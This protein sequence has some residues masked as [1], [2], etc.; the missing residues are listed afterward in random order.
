ML[1]RSALFAL[2]VVL[3]VASMALAACG[4]SDEEIIREGL[5][6]EFN[7]LKDTSSEEFSKISSQ[8]QRTLDQQGIKIEG[9]METWLEGFDYSIDSIQVDGSQATAKMTI[10]AKQFGPILDQVVAEVQSSGQQYDTIEAATTAISELLA[11]RLASAQP[12]TTT[13]EVACSKI[14]NTWQISSNVT[15]EIVMPALYGESKYA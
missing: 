7:Q 1:K 6:S 9:F 4:K 8:I 2:T 14:D 5:T 13:V 12:S 15:D 10:S 3:L 11:E